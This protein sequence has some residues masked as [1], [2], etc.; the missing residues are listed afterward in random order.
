MA[1]NVKRMAVLTVSQISDEV[2]AIIALSGIC[3]GFDV[4]Q[5][6]QRLKNN[7]DTLDDL[8]YLLEC[9]SGAFT[10]FGILDSFEP[11]DLGIVLDNIVIS[12]LSQRRVEK[13]G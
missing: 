2:S 6:L 13:A 5:Q 4:S 1:E 11:N 8:N 12:R 7:E 9:V 3:T 10:A